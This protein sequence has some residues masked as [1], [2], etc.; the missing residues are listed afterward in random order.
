MSNGIPQ[1]KPL[2]EL[3]T[4]RQRQIDAAYST[5]TGDDGLLERLR[6]GDEGAFAAFVDRYADTLLH[7]AMIYVNNRTVAEEVVQETW[8]AVLTGIHTFRG[9]SSL[10][11]WLFH[12]LTN[13]A[14]TRARREGRTLPFSCLEAMEMDTCEP[15]MHLDRFFST[16]HQWAGH[17]AS[18]PAHRRELPEEC[19]LSQETRSCLEKGIANLPAN[20]REILILRGIEGWTAQE[21]CLLLGIAEVNQRVLLHRARAKIRAALEQYSQEQ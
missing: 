17:W 4:S 3:P 16:D 10:K 15:E 12:I 20:Q 2:V 14:R 11:T 19:L 7:L 21:A 18:F 5:R 8:L 9:E 13:R 1:A 6:C